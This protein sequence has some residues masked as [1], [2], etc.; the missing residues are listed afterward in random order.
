MPRAIDHLVMPVRDL[1][2]A[3]ARFQTL[4][5]LT[6]PVARHPWGTENSLVQFPGAF[7]ELLAVPDPAAIPDAEPGAFSFGAFNRDVLAVREGTSMLVL[8]SRSAEADRAAFAAAGLPVFAPFRF[9]RQAARPDGSVRTV[10][11]SL[12][13]TASPLM[14]EVG[15]FTCE[16]HFPENFWSADLQRHPNGAA[17]IERVDLIARDPAALE[18]FF[19]AFADAPAVRTP[20]HGF[21]ID[22]GRGVLS[23]RTPGAA[24]ILYGLDTLP[25]LSP[26]PRIAVV[27]I[28]GTDRGDMADRARAAGLTTLSRPFGTL[29][30]ASDLFGTT[31]VFG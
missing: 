4:G 15:A 2:V 26:T 22:T 9:E 18:P 12:A 6:T 10:A 24:S 21:D 7:L 8:E 25:G 20:P 27:R 28:K 5:F 13:F 17:G 16:Q 31:F 1:G 23:V 11:F 19:T 30:P 29:V 3:R 14:P